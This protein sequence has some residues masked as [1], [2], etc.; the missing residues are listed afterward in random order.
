LNGLSREQD[1]S[2]DE[3]MYAESSN[4]SLLNNEF[5]LDVDNSKSNPTSN[6]EVED[7]DFSSV[8]TAILPRSQLDLPPDEN[9]LVNMSAEEQIFYENFKDGNNIGL[10]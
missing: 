9:S 1:S 5:G 4:S 8:A 2:N 7:D 6:D 10:K 3:E